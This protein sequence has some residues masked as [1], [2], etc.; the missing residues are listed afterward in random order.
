[1]TPDLPPDAEASSLVTPPSPEENA[2]IT[3]SAMTSMAACGV[4]LFPQHLRPQAS[5][6]EVTP[7]LPWL[8]RW[9]RLVLV[10]WPPSSKR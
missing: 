1:M 7:A 3:L 8:A 2:A 4:P 10:R 6:E 5:H 9:R